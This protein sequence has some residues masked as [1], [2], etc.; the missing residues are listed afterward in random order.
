MGFSTISSPPADIWNYPTRELTITKFPFWSAIIAQTYGTVSLPPNL[1]TYVIIQPPSNETWL[2]WIDFYMD[3]TTQNSEVLYHDYDG[4]TGH[5]HT[6]CRTGG[7]YGSIMPHLGVLKILTNSLY[8]RLAFNNVSASSLLGYYGYS[9]FKLSQPIWTSKKT[10]D[11]AA[12]PRPWNK[13]TEQPI[14]DMLKPLSKYIADVW[15]DVQ[16]EYVQAIVLE[17]D[18]VLAVDPDTNF[19]VERLDVV[20]SVQDFL[21]GLADFKAKPAET[22]YKKY[23]DKW[24]SEGI[25]I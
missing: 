8:A 3:T 14:P 2:V 23:F 24:A 16:E 6:S 12:S 21:K 15:S 11:A 1:M 18:T 10:S 5:R 13:P 25:V 4:S 17:K 9:G 19:P 7:T 22:G 20:I